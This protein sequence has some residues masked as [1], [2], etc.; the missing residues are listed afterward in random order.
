MDAESRVVELRRYVLRPGRRDEMIELFER[1]FLETQEAVG[2]RLLGLFRDLDAPD[3]FVWFRG[4]G[5]MAARQAALT[6][7]YTG[8]VWREHAR[9]VRRTMVDTDDVLLLRP[10]WPG[11]GFRPA[12]GDGSPVLVTT[13]PVADPEQ[14][15]RALPAGAAEACFVPEPAENTY[16][17]LPVRSGESVLVTVTRSGRPAGVPADHRTGPAHVA[18]L[19]PTARSPWPT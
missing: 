6:A 17:D 12:A 2:I 14:A 19:E 11:A 1:E 4:F 7:F 8:P 18:R 3:E 9:A 15:A 10:P 13:T 5:D 16:P